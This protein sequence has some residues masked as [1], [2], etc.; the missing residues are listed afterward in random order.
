MP[1]F[2]AFDL[3]PAAIFV[4]LPDAF[5]VPRYKYWNAAAAG[6]TGLEPEDVHGRTAIQVLRGRL[7]QVAYRT[8]LRVLN[9]G[10][11]SSYLTRLP[12]LTDPRAFQT[13]VSP[14]RGR[15][16]HVESLIGIATEVEGL[17]DFPDETA[18]LKVAELEEAERFLTMAA[19]DLRTP[20]RQMGMIGSE[21]SDLLHDPD[22]P[23]TELV[24]M[25]NQVAGG[26]ESLLRDVLIQARTAHVESKP[27]EVFDFEALCEEIFFV[28]DPFARH[29]LS[30]GPVTIETDRTALQILIR[31]LVDNA[32]KHAG[33]DRVE[34]TV[35]VGPIGTG[36]LQFSVADDGTGFTDPAV[37]FLGGGELRYDSGFG[38]YG[39][40]RLVSSRGGDISAANRPNGGSIVQF[41]FPGRVVSAPMRE[42]HETSH[43]EEAIQNTKSGTAI[44]DLRRDGH[45][46]PVSYVPPKSGLA[47]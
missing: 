28:H 22:D 19:H 31:N 21:L 5:G 25:L 10:K 34:L 6:V 13:T 23:K 2:S 37:A 16:G 20:L 8:Q 43:L 27:V 46:P 39:L 12:T 35:S 47:S 29:A 30:V 42:S 14:H 36:M 44:P 45:L 9:S 7:G 40:K 17:A 38:L 18:I 3:L 4:M 26:A 41:S 11:P 15:D 1:D 33:L 24:D 32:L